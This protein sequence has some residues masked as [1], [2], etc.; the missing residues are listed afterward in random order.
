MHK[1]C[2]EWKLGNQQKEVNPQI[3]LIKIFGFTRQ[4]EQVGSTMY[5]GG[6]KCACV[7]VCVCVLYL[8][9]CEQEPRNGTLG[10][11]SPLP[12][13]WHQETFTWKTKTKRHLHG[14]YESCGSIQ[15]V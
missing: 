8:G 9:A 5:G 15:V 14:R 4:K 2:C 1:D 6:V 7:H 13:W 3:I 10:L 11:T 12:Q